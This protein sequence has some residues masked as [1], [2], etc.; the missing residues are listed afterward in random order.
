MDH[1]LKDKQIIFFD[2][3]CGLCDKFVDFAIKYDSKRKFV[4]APLQGKTAEKL[5]LDLETSTS[6]LLWDKGELKNKSTAAILILC[7]LNWWLKPVKI[8]LLIPAFIRNWVYDFIAKNRY[9]WFGKK[10]SCRIPTKE[11]RSYF[12]D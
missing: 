9:K 5:H 4:F 2:G 1:K 8:F 3:E 10:E 7:Q 12:L 6:V 11:E